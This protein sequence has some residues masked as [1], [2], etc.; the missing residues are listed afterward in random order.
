MPDRIDRKAA[1]SKPAPVVGNT[2]MSEQERQALDAAGKGYDP[3]AGALPETGEPP[4]PEQ[5]TPATRWV[6]K[7]GD[8]DKV[9]SAENEGLVAKDATVPPLDGQR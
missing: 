4:A 3:A 5:S 6:E 2:T 9:K 7:K 1:A 8:A